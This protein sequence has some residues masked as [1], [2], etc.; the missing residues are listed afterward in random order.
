M[1]LLNK[2]LPLWVSS[3]ESDDLEARLDNNWYSPSAWAADE[4]IRVAAISRKFKLITV[5]ELCEND[6]INTGVSP[7]DDG[8]IGVIEGRNLKPNYVVPLFTKYAYEASDLKAGDLLVGKDGEPGTVALVTDS[9]LRYCPHIAVGC[10]VYHLRVREEYTVL[11]PF[12]SA[13]FNS[14]AGQALLR[15]RIAG[16]TTPTIRKSDI[17]GLPV[18][19]PADKK[20]PTEIREAILQTQE[21][22]LQSMDNLGP[23]ELA[24]KHIGIADIDVRLPVNWAGGGAS[25]SSRLLS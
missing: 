24:I 2:Q 23:S 16:G 14:R 20:C 22:I 10:H 5:L 3:L 11:A 21:S 13:F 15:K 12:I 7:E 4:E 18:I 17:A 25:R 9:L 1:E 6:G 19:I 8:E